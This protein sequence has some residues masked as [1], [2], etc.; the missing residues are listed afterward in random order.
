MLLAALLPSEASARRLAGLRIT[1]TQ[2]TG[3][4]VEFD[5]VALEASPNGTEATFP[6]G[7]GLDFERSV[8]FTSTEDL[9][10]GLAPETYLLS[11]YLAGRHGLTVAPALDFGDGSTVPTAELVAEGVAPGTG[12]RIFRGSFSHTFPTAGTYSIRATAGPSG[13]AGELGLGPATAANPGFP[14]LFGEAAVGT[15][16]AQIEHRQTVALA[17]APEVPLRKQ[18]GTD[19]LALPNTITSVS[20]AQQVQL[21]S[22][23]TAPASGCRAAAKAK[24]LVSDGAP[25]KDKVTYQWSGGV[26]AATQ[27]D[28]G[29]PVASTTWALC[30]YADG[31]LV[32]AASAPSGAA[33]WTAQK[34]SGYAYKSK[35]GAPLGATKVSFKAGAAGEPKAKAIA[36]GESIAWRE[37]VLP[38]ATPVSVTAQLVSSD[39]S[40][41]I[42]TAFGDAQVVLNA[43]PA[44]KPAVFKAQAK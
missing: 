10:F 1:V 36:K 17:S 21:A 2:V 40:R 4:D 26:E 16:F 32:M 5:V 38:F 41:C 31:E 11:G 28:F 25:D 34:T 39:G 3:A 12:F 6:L 22:C 35:D 20:I 29:D 33:G 23:P 7:S 42:S 18:A 9:G 24:L 15:V 27:A 43:A 13:E 14:L 19:T 44:D 8:S 37:P 30:L